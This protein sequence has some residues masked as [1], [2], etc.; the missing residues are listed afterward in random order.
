MNIVANADLQI[1][2]N[3]VILHYILQ[4]K[5]NKVAEDSRSI[6]T[7]FLVVAGLYIWLNYRETKTQHSA[8]IGSRSTMI[9]TTYAQY[10]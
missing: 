1:V 4:P 5:N 2:K 10:R 6:K 8:F 9:Y 7:T 3:N